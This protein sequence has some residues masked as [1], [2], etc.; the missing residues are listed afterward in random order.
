MISEEGPGDRISCT[1]RSEPSSEVLDLGFPSSGLHDRNVQFQITG[2]ITRSIT[3]T[4][5]WA[6][7]PRSC[8]TISISSRLEK[9]SV[10]KEIRSFE[11]RGLSIRRFHVGVPLHARDGSG[12]HVQGSEVGA[13]K[14]EET[15]AKPSM[16]WGAGPGVYNFV[17]LLWF[18]P[19]AAH[20]GV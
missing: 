19:A 4:N 8:L 7:S 1:M 9:M 15:S 14:R 17:D 10:I 13:H 18:C 16:R 6:S 3:S 5:D 20:L 11:V 12:R 2:I